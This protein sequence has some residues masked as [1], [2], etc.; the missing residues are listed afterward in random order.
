MR[1]SFLSFQYTNTD[2][3]SAVCLFHGSFLVND[4][5][6][7]TTGEDQNENRLENFK[8]CYVFKSSAFVDT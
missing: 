1:R 8:L 7:M 3:T 2:F 6:F 4:Q 5:I